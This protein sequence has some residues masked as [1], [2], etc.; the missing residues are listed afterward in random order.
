[1]ARITCMPPDQACLFA[2][3][4]SSLLLLLLHDVFGQIFFLLL[5]CCEQNVSRSEKVHVMKTA[6]KLQQSFRCCFVAKKK[7]LNRETSLYTLDSLFKHHSKDKLSTWIVRDF[8]AFSVRRAQSIGLRT[9]S[10]SFFYT[11]LTLAVSFW[12]RKKN[13]IICTKWTL[14]RFVCFIS[15]MNNNNTVHLS[16]RIIFFNLWL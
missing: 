9:I 8:F 3:V 11:M 7:T 14:N 4:A 2:V 5:L 12:K 10:K 1:M 16:N 15:V 13:P 6:K